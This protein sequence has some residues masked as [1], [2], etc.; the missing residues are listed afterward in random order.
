[1]PTTRSKASGKPPSTKAAPAKPPSKKKPASKQ[2][3]KAKAEDK[4]EVGSKRKAEEA[5]GDGK[6][7]HAGKQPPEKKPKEDGHKEEA[8]G[9]EN[10]VN[11]VKNQ[12]DHPGKHVYQSGTVERGHIYFFYR[13]KVEVE[14]VHSIDDVQRFHILLV[15]RPP[16][17]SVGDAT[18][19]AN[20]DEGEMN[21]VQEGADAVPAKATIGEKKKHFRLVAVGKK[22][23]P[24]PDAGGGKGGDRKGTF[25]ATVITVGEDLQKL[26]EGLGKKEY[27]TKTKG[28]RHQGPARLAARGAYAIVNSQGRTP[29]SRETHLGYH[30][31]HPTPENFGE[32]QEALGIHQASSFVVQVKN[33]KA[34]NT[35]GFNVGLPD[36]RKADF[37]QDIM[38]EVFGA[39]GGKGR[40]SFGLRFATV[41]RSEMLDYE[42]AELLLIAARSGDDGLET[43]LKEGR[44]EALTEL[45]EKE[46][47]ESIDQVL[48][49]L[50]I[51]AHNIPAEPLEGEWV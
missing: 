44:G 31:S 17:F 37:P 27:E 10:K 14:E 16:E 36:G 20:E 40:E 45:G 23:L 11:A 2:Q 51:N 32:V 43:S 35:A 9:G 8:D 24:D 38:R 18:S 48:K 28:T 33:P 26:Q 46:S 42:G 39:G 30:L 4:P 21:L 50:A 19:G 3:T 41:E 5:A 15:P 7:D 29:S 6:E 34:P 25:W 22:Q 12:G 47:E 49:E 1:M 13:P